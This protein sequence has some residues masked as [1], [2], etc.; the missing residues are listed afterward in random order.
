[1][2]HRRGKNTRKV[3]ERDLIQQPAQG[4]ILRAG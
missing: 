2:Y 3:D 4:I 1:M